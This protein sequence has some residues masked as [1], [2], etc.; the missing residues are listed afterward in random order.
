MQ[1]GI[2]NLS[3][4]P[5]RKSP[6]HT[7]E[8]VSQLLFGE[9]FDILEKHE[10]WLQIQLHNDAYTGWIHHRQ[11]LALTKE[12]L[13]E[14]RSGTRV[15]VCDLNAKLFEKNSYNT[16][17]LLMG[18]SLLFKED[19]T[20]QFGDES[21]VFT[22]DL[23]IPAAKKEDILRFAVMY[24]GAPYLWGGRSHFG[25]DCSGF[26]QMAYHLAGFNLPRDASQQAFAGETLSFLSE[27]EPGDLLFFDNAE[28][29]IVHVGIYSG[30]HK[31]IHASGN[32]R[33]DNI[34]HQ[35]IFNESLQ[36][37]THQL[38]LVKRIVK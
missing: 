7:A 23:Y 8:M 30:N 6:E 24:L 5:L 15:I 36:Q 19:N 26:S 2:C 1:Y 4:I 29:K 12:E 11:Y 22:G 28:G 33:I 35:G 18:S 27:A 32:V 3:L 14:I 13:D 21:Y 20:F 16:F 31:I 17:P 38:R 25:I 34:D 9:S 37:Y 10:N